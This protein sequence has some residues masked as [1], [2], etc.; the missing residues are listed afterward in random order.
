MDFAQM[1]DSVVLLQFKYKPMEEAKSH[2]N[3][4]HSQGL[5]DFVPQKYILE[6]IHTF[7]SL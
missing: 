7:Q 3:G 4:I 5:A 6:I 2:Q 1:S